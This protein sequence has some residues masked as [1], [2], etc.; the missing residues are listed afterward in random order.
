MTDAPIIETGYENLNPVE[1]AVSQRRSVRAFL[2]DPVLQE[3]VAY[4]FYYWRARLRWPL[5][6]LGV[7][8]PSG[9]GKTT[10]LVALQYKPR[11][12]PTHNMIHLNLQQH[13]HS[14]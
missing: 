6:L 13:L 5:R 3:N 12:Q 10:L 4:L 11:K 9:A 1:E 8:G 2:P 14:P 7:L